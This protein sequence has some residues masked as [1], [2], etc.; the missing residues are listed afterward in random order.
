MKLRSDALWLRMRGGSSE[1]RNELSQ[2]IEEKAKETVTAIKEM[3]PAVGIRSRTG[4]LVNAVKYTMRS[5]LH[6]TIFIDSKEA[7][8]AGYLEEGYSP[9]DMKR[10]LLKSSKAKMSRE[11]HRYIRIPINDEIRTVSEKTKRMKNYISLWHH[12]GYTGKLFFRQGIE[13]VE[14]HIVRRV[15]E[16]LSELYEE[17]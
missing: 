9:F 15:E 8:Y 12:P 14:P 4:K 7:P 6:A 10:G 2:I 3:I 5:S 1:I 11:G 16:R 17:E 13:E